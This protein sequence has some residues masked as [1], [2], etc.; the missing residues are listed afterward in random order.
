MET[1]TTTTTKVSKWGQRVLKKWDEF[2]SNPV[3]Q[4]HMI[5]WVEMNGKYVMPHKDDFE[6]TFRV[7]FE[8]LPESLR[9]KL[10]TKEYK[11]PS[12]KSEETCGVL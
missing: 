7:D 12:T 6:F 4:Q 9:A 5:D 10:S 3:H 8:S 2:N 11:K 1:Q